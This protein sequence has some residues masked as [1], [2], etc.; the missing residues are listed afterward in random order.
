MSK[1]IR[2]LFRLAAALPLLLPGTAGA[3]A[4]PILTDGYMT[5]WTVGP[6]HTDPSGDQGASGVDFQNLWI[7]ND[8]DWLFIRFETTAVIDLNEGPDMILGI[9]SDQ[10]GATGVAVGSLGCELVWQFDLRRGIFF[11][12][13]PAI[14]VHFDDVRI[15]TAPTVTGSD[16]EVA[17]N[18]HALPDG[19]NTLFNGNDIR[20]AIVDE[21]SGDRLPDGTGGVD[22]SFVSGVPFGPPNDLTKVN[23]TDV[24]FMT[25]N[26]L[27]NNIAD[28]ALDPQLDRVFSAIDPQIINVQ[29]VF[30]S[31]AQT[32][33]LIEGWLPSGVDENWFAFG[34][35]DVVTV[36][37][38]P[39]V[40]LWTIGGNFAGLIDVSDDLGNDLLVI[41]THLPCC[42]DDAGRQVEADAIMEFVRDAITPGGAVNVAANT[43]IVLTG[44][45]NLVGSRQ[46][47]ITLLTGD[48]VDEVTYGPD[49]A[50]D[51]DGTDLF[52]LASPQTEVRMPYT[53]K[54]QN[55]FAG[56]DMPGRLDMILF[57]DSVLGVGNRFNL[58]TPNM[59]A[60]ELTALNLQADDVTDISDHIPHVCDFTG[61]TT[62]VGDAGQSAPP[63]ALTAFPNP[64]RSRVAISI[65]VTE[66]MSLDVSVFD[67]RG[68]LVARTGDAAAGLIS[69]GGR[70]DWQGRDSSGRPAPSGAYF[71]RVRG[72]NGEGRVTLEQTVRVALLR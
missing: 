25:W 12:T 71:V 51:W 9:D 44:D 19:V 18:R 47:L 29:E 11:I 67:A 24:R 26:M 14:V 21:A 23:A 68:R 57:T 3:D 43:G 55:P 65:D 66:S 15:R 32:R 60:G 40:G 38:Y 1:S 36:S 22:Y 45:M 48:I 13:P 27:F 50:P 33:A 69:S 20:I 4:L 59:S 6:V 16:F 28:P 49:F 72:T 41:N 30:E 63:P 56:A 2:R 61:S 64:M 31:P 46:Q 10:N 54:K 35:S 70:I 7:A 34:T 62:G 58:F 17:I 5:D 52:D 42:D 39:F 37:R 8:D 53:W